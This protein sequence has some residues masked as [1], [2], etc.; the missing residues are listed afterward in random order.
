MKQLPATPITS[1]LAALGE[2]VR[3][4]ILR[5]LELQELAVGEVAKVVQLPQS[6][7]S[8]HLKVLSENQWVERRAEGTAT[9]YRV[10]LDDLP[11]DAR[12]LW[13]VVREQIGHPAELEEDARRL[14]AVL[15]E[16]RTDSQAFFGRVAG[17]W[18]ALRTELFG[19]RFTTQAILSFL[20]ADWTV[21]DLGCGTG[22]VAEL[23]APVVKQVIAIDQSDAMLAAARQRLTG[24]TN[25]Q[26]VAAELSSL[27]IRDQSADAVVAAL[28]LHHLVEPLDALREARRI[29]RE[30]HGM[31]L[32][33]DM[34]AHD[35]EDYR[36]TMGH[37]HL[38]FSRR[39]IEASFDQAG[40]VLRNYRELPIAA[41]GKGPGLFAAVGQRKQT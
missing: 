39:Q 2:L 24:L 12:R 38:G 14:E 33:I 37:K 35:R 26:F 18:D 15:A 21:A 5:L 3:L 30:P 17:E 7:V 22:N 23:L 16:R 34:V 6:T 13:V 1:R 40:L 27:P 36:H 41:D 31:V 9:L 19:D 11:P 8:R 20:P 28:V 29:V 4:R 10:I 32:V 25:V